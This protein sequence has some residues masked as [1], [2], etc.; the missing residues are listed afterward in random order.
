MPPDSKKLLF[1]DLPI[2]FIQAGLS[3]F[4]PAEPGLALHKEA[5]VPSGRFSV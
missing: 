3:L 4:S 5:I 1:F 2:F